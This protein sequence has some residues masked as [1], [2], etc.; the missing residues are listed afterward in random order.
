MT[1]RYHGRVTDKRPPSP[2]PTSEPEPGEAFIQR[3]P[4]AAVLGAFPDPTAVK[5]T[6][7][8]YRFVNAAF[9][10]WH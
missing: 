8:V 4:P 5:D 3:L 9:C 2:S 10:E 6:A 7:Y 1:E